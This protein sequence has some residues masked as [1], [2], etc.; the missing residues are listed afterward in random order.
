MPNGKHYIAAVI[1]A[2]DREDS[3]WDFIPQVSQLVY[4]YFNNRMN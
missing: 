3:A 2:S 1:V 4:T